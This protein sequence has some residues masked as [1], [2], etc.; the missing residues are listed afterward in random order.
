[1]NEQDIQQ[2]MQIR[3]EIHEEIKKIGS[4]TASLQDATKSLL[5]QVDV[6]KSLSQTAQEQ[7]KAIIND[8]SHDMAHTVSE[9]LYSK[10]E[11]KVQEILT[12]LDQS[13]QYARRTLDV[14]KGVKLRKLVL[15]C[16][17][18]GLFCCF[19]GASLGYFYAKRHNYALPSDFIKMYA[20][21]YEY[22]QILSKKNP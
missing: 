18:G 4:H 21:G 7:M 8:A 10:L 20:L 13:V 2:F 1:M 9:D 11:G 17:I 15:L 19:M 16:S 22:K 3:D 14:S 5:S 12:P 6:F